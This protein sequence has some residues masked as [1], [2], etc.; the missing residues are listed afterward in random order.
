MTSNGLT[1][2]SKI[3][4]KT[5]VRALTIIFIGCMTA[6]PGFAQQPEQQQ[7][8]ETVQRI[9][10]LI[11]RT[12]AMNRQINQQI[13]QLQSHYQLMHR[14]NEQMQ[15]TLGNMKNAAEQF[16]LM[17]QD[18]EMMRDQEMR[19]D[20]EQLREHLQGMATQADEALQVMERVRIRLQE[21]EGSEIETEVENE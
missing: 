3:P 2:Y 10:Q 16:N 1:E 4:M 18:E 9:N 21:Q 15:M 5:L 11:E 7:M 12:H 17:F 19:K 13:Q 8:Q 6:L 20:M 14:F